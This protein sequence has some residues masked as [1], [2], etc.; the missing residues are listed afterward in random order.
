MGDVLK[1]TSVSAVAEE[2]TVVVTF[3][4]TEVR[5]LYQTGFEITRA[6]RMACKMAMK[7]EGVPN[8]E[9]RKLAASSRSDGPIPRPHHCF[10]RSRGASA[11]I[12]VWR[13]AFEGSLVCLHLGD[14]VVRMHYADA[15]Q[16]HTWIRRASKC[17]KAWAGDQSRMVSGI[18]YLSDA[19][20]NYRRYA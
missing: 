11:S 16:L 4:S 12:S 1:Q 20:E 8:T 5:L 17:A 3:G 18:A 13:V 15:F 19:E 9:W 14:T 6:M 7:H 10:R 2:D